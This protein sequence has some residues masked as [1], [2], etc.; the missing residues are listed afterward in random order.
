MFSFKASIF[1]I[2]LNFCPFYLIASQSL[3]NSQNGGV[4]AFYF[5]L[6]TFVTLNIGLPFAVSR[7]I[8]NLENNATH[9][10]F[11]YRKMNDNYAMYEE[12]FENT[13]TPTLLCDKRGKLL[14]ANQLARRLL[15]E[16]PK[17]V[18]AGTLLIDWLSPIN[19]GNKKSLN[20][21]A[22]KNNLAECTLKTNK[23]KT[24][25]KG[26]VYI[27]V[28]KAPLTQ[29]GHVVLHLQNTTPLRAIQQELANTLQTNTRLTHFDLLTQLPNH[30]H[31]CQ[32]VN[33]R[34]NDKAQHLTGAM[35]I[36][37]ISQFKLLNKQYG[38]DSANKVILD[39]SNALQAKL[40]DQAIVGRLRGVKFSCF[41][42]L[43]QA[44]LLPRHLSTLIHSVLPSQ[45]MVHGSALNMDYQ[46]GIAYYDSDGKSAEEL[47]EHCELALEYS[48]S[49]GRFSYYNQ[50]LES[51]LLEE[52]SLGLSLNQAIKNKEIRVWLQPQVSGNGQIR[53][54]EALARWQNNG[55]FVPPNVFIDIAEK[56]G[57]LP[58]LAENLIHEL[59]NTLIQWHKEQIHTPIAFNLAGQE[60]MND[61]F[62]ALLMSLISDHP[63]LSEML[64][65][66]ITETSPVMTHPLIHKRLRSLSQ[67]GY[68][69]AIDDFGTG[70]ASLGQLIDI[71]VD[72]LKIDR[73]FVAPL[74]HD[75]RHIDIVKST[76]KLAESLNMKVI[77]EGIETKE[78]AT[79]LTSLGCEILQGY[80]FGKPSPLSEW[81]DQNHAKAKAL[82]MVY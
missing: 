6:L 45:I 70:Q 82:R 69:I 62:F 54:F 51:K 48:N 60:L 28:K 23:N 53:S 15:S 14:K 46:V 8:K 55:Q 73:R 43:G 16:N 25:D 36:I 78:Q 34:I 31:F 29:Y 56:L 68:S 11:L 66:E 18:F 81:T 61:G 52:H 75:Q 21:L 79:L 63:W 9:M 41:I 42:P 40:S 27:E 12:F 26:I 74:P 33:Q 47:L 44:Y 35:F 65:L 49:S 24:D 13:G 57:M 22:W 5:Q 19:S 64:E 76:I 7:I 80:Y 59:M 30:R 1:A 77:A 2:A 38:R 17:A 32:Q 50:G 58:L 67:Y 37:R 4:S 3:S 20:K 72:V 10:S 71:P 39:F